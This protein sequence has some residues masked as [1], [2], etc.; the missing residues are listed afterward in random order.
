MF[1]GR[2]FL[3]QPPDYAQVLLSLNTARGRMFKGCSSTGT[4]EVQAMTFHAHGL[5]CIVVSGHTPI[6]Q[7][8]SI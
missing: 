6:S 5:A 1:L 8:F 2:K 4:E 3:L 7:S